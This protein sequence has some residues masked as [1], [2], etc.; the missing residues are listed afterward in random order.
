MRIEIDKTS[1]DDYVCVEDGNDITIFSSLPAV[2]KYF[3]DRCFKKFENITVMKTEITC[4]G[5]EHQC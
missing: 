2:C 1:H 5:S 4:L 3:T